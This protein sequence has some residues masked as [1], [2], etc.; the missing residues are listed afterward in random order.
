MKR[1]ILHIDVNFL[2][3]RINNCRNLV[4]ASKAF[5]KGDVIKPDGL[6]FVDYL[7]RNSELNNLC[8]RHGTDKGSLRKSPDLH[9]LNRQVHS[10]ADFYEMIFGSMR[11]LPK[12][13][14]FECG[15]GTDDPRLAS[16]MG[17]KGKPGAS[18]RVWRDWFEDAT[19]VGADIDRKILFSEPG[20][21]TFYVDQTNPDS[22]RSLWK[23]VDV[24]FFHI[25][26]DDGLHTFEAG[27]ILFENSIEKLSETGYYIIEDVRPG[28]LDLFRKFF[29]N[30]SEK[31]YYVRLIRHQHSLGDN[32]LLV[33]QK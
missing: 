16:T 7:N 6:F 26:I 28:D 17:L 24:E 2:K 18:L 3:S 30:R 12:V 11:R 5:R 10:Y 23:D 14:V 29:H 4:H 1:L 21:A 32:T 20:I 31:V 19:I 13:K 9:T 8:Q 25:M 15:I 33:I 22:I 27:K